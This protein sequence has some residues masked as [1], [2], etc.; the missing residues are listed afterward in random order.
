LSK[1]L[2]ETPRSVSSISAETIDLFGLSAIEDLVRLVPGTFTT[3]RFGIQ[4]SVDV[5]NVPADFYFR[6]MKRLSLQGHGRSVL[7][8]LDTIEVVRGPPSPI[9]GMGKIGG[10]INV[11]PTSGRAQNGSYREGITGF[12]KGVVG[13]YDRSEWSFGFGGSLDANGRR[14]GYYIHGLFEDSDSFARGVPIKQ[15]LLQA[16]ISIDDFA[17]RCGSNSAQTHNSRTPLAR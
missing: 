9:F 4:G 10:Y 12:A 16:A 1:F 3:T 2:I 7:G 15:Q 14:G 13:S 5:R 17:G 11:E 8:A 6:G